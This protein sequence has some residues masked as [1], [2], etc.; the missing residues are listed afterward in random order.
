ME[1]EGGGKVDGEGRRISARE[2]KVE[3]CTSEAAAAGSADALACLAASA[4]AAIPT[5]GTAF[6]IG[7][8]PMPVSTLLGPV[9]VPKED[10]CTGRDTGTALGGNMFLLIIMVVV[11]F[12][13]RYDIGLRV[14]IVPLAF[15]EVPR[16]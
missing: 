10:I 4:A 14:G 13:G 16:A 11:C 5:L 3:G 7:C 9:E 1:E 12:R 15:I 8:V 2:W 6:R